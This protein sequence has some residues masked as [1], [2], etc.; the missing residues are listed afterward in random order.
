MASLSKALGRLAALAAA[1]VIPIESKREHIALRS[2]AEIAPRTQ[3]L[4]PKRIQKN[5]RGKNLQTFIKQFRMIKYIGRGGFGLVAEAQSSMD[6]KLYAIKIGFGLEHEAEILASISPHRN[7]VDLVSSWSEPCSEELFNEINIGLGIN[8]WDLLRQESDDDSIFEVSTDYELSDS[9][10]GGENF[11]KKVD[12]T[13]L[14]FIQ[15]QLCNGP[16]LKDYLKD[17]SGNLTIQ[18]I[19]LMLWDMLLGVQHMH[20]RHIVHS[21][22]IYE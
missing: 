18:E 9:S 13:Q 19:I 3:I 6:R 15:M 10:I 14:N 16:S 2:R 4:S 1:P 17:L 11:A 8:L 21:K 7:I 20:E 12:L 22:H 5:A